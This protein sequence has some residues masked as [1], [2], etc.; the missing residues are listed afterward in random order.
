MVHSISGDR[1]ELRTK[2][3][4]EPILAH[5][6]AREMKD[7]EET[8]VNVVKAL[9]KNVTSGTIHLRDI[10]EMV[11]ALI[12]LLTVDKAQTES[13]PTPIRFSDFLASLLSR[14][15]RD[16]LQECMADDVD[17]YSLLTNGYVF[18]NHF[19][20][21]N[22]EITDRTLRRAWSRGMAL[23]APQ[24]SKAYDLVIPVGLQKVNKMSY[25]V[26]QVKKG[27]N[28]SMT[29]ALRTEGADLMR[30]AAKLLPE[31]SAHMGILMSLRNKTGVG[32]IDMVLPQKRSQDAAGGGGGS[33]ST[34]AWPGNRKGVVVVAVGL[35]FPLYPGLA[36]TD[37]PKEEPESQEILSILK[38]LLSDTSEIVSNSSSTYTKR[39]QTTDSDQESE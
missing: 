30:T 36:F 27:K 7:H 24:C 6:A 16:T 13:L 22:R 28:D 11:A 33:N 35:D 29:A 15:M 9:H 25:F 20:R 37:H 38:N 1:R 4:S 32:A 39:M 2:H 8:R 5:M 17:M 3:P 26:V 14:T 31:T 34:Y 23:L 19:T 12:L 21:A 10:G 18:F